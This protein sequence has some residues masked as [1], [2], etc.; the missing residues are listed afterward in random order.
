M[1]SSETQL[2]DL[3]P[4]GPYCYEILEVEQA[5][6][7]GMPVIRTKRCPFHQRVL[8]APDCEGNVYWDGECTLLGEKDNALL[9]DFC[10]ICG[11]NED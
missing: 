4:V 3:I 6:D 8:Q 10:K 1:V 2:K 9:F 5:A 7:S 11:I